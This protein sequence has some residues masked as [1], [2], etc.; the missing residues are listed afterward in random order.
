MV[1]MEA[2][3]PSARRDLLVSIAHLAETQHG[4]FSRAQALQT[5]LSVRTIERLVSSRTWESVHRGVYRLPGL[6]PTLHQKLMAACLAA[7]R[8]AVVSHRAAA[9]LWMLDGVPPGQIEVTVD[10]PGRAARPGF[11]VFR[12]ISLPRCDRAAVSGIPVTE[13]SRTL[14]DLGAVAKEAIVEQALD[15]ALRRRLTSI[16]RLRW[17]LEELGRR[18][19]PGVAILRTILAHR[20]PKTA[21]PE[22]IFEARV[23]KLLQSLG[24]PPPVRQ[25]EVRSGGRLIARIDLAYPEKMLAIECEGFR[26]HSS[27]VDWDRDLKRRNLLTRLGWRV[28]HLTWSDLQGNHQDLKALLAAFL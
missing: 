19:R 15:D 27:R 21:I 26:N 22:S 3:V 8:S 20:D 1:S 10:L 6:R 18:G 28:V 7:G 13:V 2:S 5:G 14:L 16:P 9:A 24:L 11:T 4:V 25:H 23:I 12:T 17:R